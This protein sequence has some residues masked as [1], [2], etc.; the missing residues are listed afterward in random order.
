MLKIMKK[1]LTFLAISL[2]MTINAKSDFKVEEYIK[3]LEENKD[4]SIEQLFEMYP[5][6]AFL[7]E[8]HTNF[9][10]AEYSQEIDS[11]FKLTDYEKNLIQRH[12]FMVTERLSYPTFIHA[13]WDVF[14]KDMPIYISTDAM[15]HALHYTFGNLL[16]HFEENIAYNKLKN[17][18]TNARDYMQNVNISNLPE[19]YKLAI[20]DMDV[21]FTVAANLLDNRE[22][23]LFEQNQKTTDEILALIKGMN[24]ESYPLFSKKPRHI[25]FSQFEVRGHYTRKFILERYFKAMM[26]FGRTE[27]LITSPENDPS[28]QFDAEDLDRMTLLAALIAETTHKSGADKDFAWIDSLLVILIGEQDNIKLR[29]IINVLDELQLTAIE[30]LEENNMKLFRSKLLELSS[31]QQL[32]I[33]QILFSDP[34]DPNQVIPPSTFLLMGQRPII[35]G[36]ITAN[37]TYDNILYRGRKVLRMVPSTLDILFALGNDASIQLL[38]DEMKKYPYMS[39]LA[40]LRYLID[41]YDD[42]FW[43]SNVYGKWIKSIRSLNPPLKRGNLPSF[44][45]TAAWWQKTINTQLASWAEL[46]H[47]FQLYGKQPYTYSN[48]CSFPHGYVEPVQE[49]YENLKKLIK[50]I[51]DFLPLEM[52]P[53]FQR[54]EYACD[55][56]K[57]ISEKILQGIEFTDKENDFLCTAIKRGKECD[58]NSDSRIGWYP[59]LYSG[60][61]VTQLLW[62]YLHGD[63][64]ES[65]KAIV[66]DVHTIPTDEGGN[67]VGWVLHAGTGKINMA[68]ITA[69]TSDGG[70][71]SYIGPVSSYYE[72][73]SNDFKRLT[74][75]EWREMDGEPANRP[76]FTNLYLADKNGQNPEGDLISLFTYT[77][78]HVDLPPT[79]TQDFKLKNQP[80][81]FNQMT[82]INFVIPLSLDGQRAKL[83]IHD[84]NGNL[85]NILVDRIL[86]ANSYSIVWNGLDNNGLKLPTGVYFYTLEIGKSTQTGKLSLVR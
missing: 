59:E 52:V 72:F 31:A 33:S 54:W 3:F 16:A 26:W 23:C 81:P 41:S 15:L 28:N 34:S 69:P 37:V 56:L 12:G 8:Y 71:R 45:Q 25:D 50:S 44:M 78:N 64:L 6:G 40:A 9:N 61:G 63:G 62:N 14:I 80:N 13:Y 2:F 68:V 58:P 73:I 32:Y 18:V 75:A 39:N 70:T 48:V 83:T 4:M 1:L 17:A 67:L 43:N 7:K 20:M 19:N 60:F 66:A 35:D 47:D 30:L 22:N 21:Y 46:R 74:N 24:Y 85:V 77:S 49:F 82:V 84:S 10:N 11:I 79:R 36:F 57:S 86:T 38:I 55:N 42:D 5:A 65:D 29:E 51:Y 53:I 76:A 27:L